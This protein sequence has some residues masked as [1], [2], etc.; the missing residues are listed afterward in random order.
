MHS[1][2]LRLYG[3]TRDDVEY[4]LSTFAATSQQDQGELTG[5]AA[6]AANVLLDAYDKLAH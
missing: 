6:S 1:G 5:E 4:V 2:L 3:F